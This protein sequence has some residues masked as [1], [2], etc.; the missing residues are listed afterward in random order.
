LKLNKLL[1]LTTTLCLA[2]GTSLF[3]QK[4]AKRV[5]QI[6]GEYYEKLVKNGKLTM[7]S[8]LGSANLWLLPQT[9]Y[10]FEIKNSLVTKQEKDFSFTYETLYYIEKQASIEK[11]SEIARSISKMEGLKYY[12]TTKKKEQVLY[13]NA[14]MVDGKDS[15]KEIPDQ[16]KGNADGQ[17]SYCLMDDNHFGKTIYELSY[18]QSK[19][20]LLTTFSN[21]DDMGYGPFRLIQPEKLVINLLVE[22][23]EDGIVVYLCAD[24]SCKNFPGLKDSITDSISTRIDAISKWFISLL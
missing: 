1:L 18:N 2:G 10:A 12:S 13:K 4:A 6:T 24:L 23:C 20:E 8:V 5:E 14:Y 11:I 15:K 16:N 21:Q 17:I 9:E 3:A 7:S 19:E 22:P